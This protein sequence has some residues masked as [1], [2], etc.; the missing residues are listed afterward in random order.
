MLRFDRFREPKS[1]IERRLHSCGITHPASASSGAGSLYT[2]Q[3]VS[4]PIPPLGKAA[5]VCVNEWVTQTGSD[6]FLQKLLLGG[7]IR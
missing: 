3:I 1:W 6:H 4:E 5:I 2:V 7:E